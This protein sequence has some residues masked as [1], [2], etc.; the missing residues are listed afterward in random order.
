MR[1]PQGGSSDRVQP[2]TA[3]TEAVGYHT[4][5]D[6]PAGRRPTR[7]REEDVARVPASRRPADRSSPAVPSWTSSVPRRSA[8]TGS[9]GFA[10]GPARRLLARLD[11]AQ[12]GLRVRLDDGLDVE[13]DLDGRARRAGRRGRAPGR[14]GDPLRGPAVRSTCEVRRLVIHI[15]GLRVQPGGAP[16]DGRRRGPDARSA[17]AT[18]PT[19][20]R[21]SPDG[22][23]GLRRGRPARGLPGGGREPRGPRRRDQRASTSTRS[24]TATPARTCTRPC[25]RRSRRPRRRPAQPADRVAAAISFGAL[26][27]ARGNS[28][29][30]TSQI[31]RGM[32]EGLDG[33]AAVQ[34]ARPGPRA[35]ARARRPPTPRSPSRSRARS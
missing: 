34:R 30:I 7:R 33:Q 17:P 21:T 20:G 28:G 27:G 25:G 32:A 15:D 22:P 14:F 23:P 2:R 9:P 8:R 12:P 4:A 31:F 11:L 1:G 13:L 3:R 35:V 29:V 18:S 5:S 10:G 16:P 26:M 6:A 24:P 19:A